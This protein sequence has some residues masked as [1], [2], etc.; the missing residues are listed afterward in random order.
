MHQ[1]GEG[2]DWISVEVEHHHLDIGL[3][4]LLM[5][6]VE[7]CIT[8]TH[9]LEL[10]KEIDDELCKRDGVLHGYHLAVVEVLLT[11]WDGPAIMTQRLDALRILNWGHD[12]GGANWLEPLLYQIWVLYVQRIVHLEA[13][14]GIQIPSIVCYAWLSDDSVNLILIN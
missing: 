1:E 14:L 12:R 6:V 9:R 5:L 13:L 4:V 3:L 11:L 2:V 8:L 7:G 10:V